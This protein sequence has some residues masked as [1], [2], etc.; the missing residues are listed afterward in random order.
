MSTEVRVINMNFTPK[1]YARYRRIIPKFVWKC[2]GC[3]SFVFDRDTHEMWHDLITR[4]VTMLSKTDPDVGF[5]ATTKD[6]GG[7]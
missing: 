1:P 7:N 3:G 2:K 6:V 5:F 4:M